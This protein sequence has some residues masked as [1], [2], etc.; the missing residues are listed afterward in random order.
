MIY[1]ISQNEDEGVDTGDDDGMGEHDDDKMSKDEGIET[2]GEMEMV[3]NGGIEH[4]KF[5][6]L[7]YILPVI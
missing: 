5:F 2:D 1:R 4:L 7:Y 6:I 3:E